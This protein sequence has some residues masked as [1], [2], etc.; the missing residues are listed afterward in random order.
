MVP[1]QST[2]HAS[3]WSCSCPS[4]QVRG[5]DIPRPVKTWTQCGINVKVLD[6]LKKHGFERP[7]A[8]QAQVRYRMRCWLSHQLQLQLKARYSVGCTVCGASLESP[9]S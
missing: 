4:H 8:I 3:A 7:L 6:V 1:R 5:Q 2:S 9:G